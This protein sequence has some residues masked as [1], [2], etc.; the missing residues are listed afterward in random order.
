MYALRGE[1]IV[2]AAPSLVGLCPSC[3]G[4]VLA[5]CGDVKVWH[6][7]HE[8]RDCD[9]W[10]EPMSAWHL[11]WQARADRDT[12]EI[13]IDRDGVRHRAD[14]VLR[15]GAILEIQRSP[16]SVG[17]IAE[18][19]RFYGRMA[20][21]FDASQWIK[22]VDGPWP[23]GSDDDPRYRWVSKPAGLPVRFGWSCARPSHRAIAAPIFW[24]VGDGWV[25]KVRR[26]PNRGY[27][28]WTLTDRYTVADFSRCMFGA[29]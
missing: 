25:W 17:E 23:W 8:A 4:S 6:W 11:G 5:K 22:N 13:T 24:D 20:W 21:L 2:T 27:D 7:A 16:I 12:V 29:R 10:S 18:R 28:N 1:K 9:P 26:F 15:D 14:V 19:E 3:A